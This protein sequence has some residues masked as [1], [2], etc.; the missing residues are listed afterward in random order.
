MVLRFDPF[1]DRRFKVFIWLAM[2][3][4]YVHG[5]SKHTPKSITDIILFNRS[6][7]VYVMYPETV[8]LIS[9]NYRLNFTINVNTPVM[10]IFYYRKE[11]FSI[12]NGITCYHLNGNC[13]KF[14]FDGLWEIFWNQGLINNSRQH[15]ECFL[16]HLV[17]ILRCVRFSCWHPFLWSS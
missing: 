17:Y 14:Y 9:I 12:C 5:N 13:S 15:L 3:G 6:A 4:T 8:A 16:S 7:S 10:F 2:F 1:D 11:E